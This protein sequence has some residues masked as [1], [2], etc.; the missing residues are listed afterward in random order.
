MGRPQLA[1]MLLKLS[2]HLRPDLAK[3]VAAF[4]EASAA[5]DDLAAVAATLF[6]NFRTKKQREAVQ[7]TVELFSVLASLGEAKHDFATL[8]SSIAKPPPSP[9]AKRVR[10]S[11][12]LNRKPRTTNQ[13]RVSKSNEMELEIADRF[14]ADLLE[15]QRDRDRFPKLHQQLKDS[16][17]VNTATLHHIAHVFLGNNESYSGRKRALDDILRRHHDALRIAE[18][19][20]ML[21]RLN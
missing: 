8:A 18:Q 1:A 14:A 6:A 17:R 4:A 21:D 7:E 3:V 2:K 12:Q 10:S 5:S 19:D 13:P 16:K 9:A 15:A 11:R 20:R